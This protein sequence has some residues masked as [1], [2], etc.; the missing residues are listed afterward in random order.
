MAQGSSEDIYFE[1][2]DQSVLRWCESRAPAHYQ[3]LTDTDIGLLESNIRQSAGMVF[4]LQDSDSRAGLYIASAAHPDFDTIM[5]SL[6]PTRWINTAALKGANNIYTWLLNT[7]DVGENRLNIGNPGGHRSTLFWRNISRN[8]TRS[9]LE[10]RRVLLE[11]DKVV[12]IIAADEH[13]L[14]NQIIELVGE[15]FSSPV[16][17]SYTYPLSSPPSWAVALDSFGR[18]NA[19][20]VSAQAYFIWPYS[21]ENLNAIPFVLTSAVVEKL[22]I[23]ARQSAP[24][25]IS[26]IGGKCLTISTV[27]EQERR[28]STFIDEAISIYDDSFHGTTAIEGSSAIS[29]SF[30][31]DEIIQMCHD[32]NSVRVYTIRESGT[33]RIVAFYFGLIDL[34]NGL[35]VYHTVNPRYL[36]NGVESARLHGLLWTISMGVA[37]DYQRH[38]ALAFPK[39]LVYMLSQSASSFFGGDVAFTFGGKNGNTQLLKLADIMGAPWQCVDVQRVMLKEI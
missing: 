9:D 37:R 20:P 1:R 7:N 30:T 6:T 38:F 36:V 33:N 12:H 2:L 27:H 15:Y 21:R 3:E 8:T 19:D 39:A 11:Q 25:E 13:I 28:S 29:Q 22:E 35:N 31:H 24:A 26:N 10:R 32:V 23:A 17:L 34:R 18:Y 5:A 16:V 14:P 4:H